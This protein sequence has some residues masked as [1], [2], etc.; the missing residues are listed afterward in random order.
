MNLFKSALFKSAAILS[1]TA[2]FAFA[3]PDAGSM[4]VSGPSDYVGSYTISNGSQSFSGYGGG[5]LGTVTDS[6][7]NRSTTQLLF[8]NDFSNDISVPSGQIA[9]Y[10]S[11]LTGG[12][13]I[14][15]TRFGNVSGN[16][17][18][19]DVSLTTTQ[20]TALSTNTETGLNGA[21]A[22]QRYQMAAYLVTQ[23]AFLGDHPAAN[24]VHSDNVSRGIQ[25]AIWTL[26]DANGETF[27]P[28]LESVQA[29]Q[30]GNVTTYLTAAANWLQSGDRSFLNQFSVVTDA[31]MHSLN[32][33]VQELLLYTPVPE[34]G[35][36]ALLGLGL[37]GLGWTAR[38]RRHA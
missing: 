35:Y 22:L 2:A 9:V 36:D 31:S 38:R 23:Y 37:L 24:S 13:D 4:V 30:T 14:T 8:C 18:A 5:Y 20:A 15:K 28:P 34:P 11:Q 26:L 3:Y 33:G 16:F 12:S 25:E 19:I 1:L 32:T 21:T 29:G 10:I 7:T 27:A 6:V 17:R